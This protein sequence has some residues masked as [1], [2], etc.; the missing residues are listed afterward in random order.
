MES[1]I[2]VNFFANYAKSRHMNRGGPDHRVGGDAIRARYR[3][4]RLGI[5]RLEHAHE[6][7]AVRHEIA[8]DRFDSI[9]VEAAHL[10]GHSAHVGGSQRLVELAFEDDVLHGSIVPR[11]SREAEPE[12]SV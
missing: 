11:A 4:E 6:P 9:E 12:S 1:A 10:R 7:L 3:A 8:S 5:G 2:A